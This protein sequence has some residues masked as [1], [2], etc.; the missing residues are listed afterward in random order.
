MTSFS[1]VTWLPLSRQCPRAS[2]CFPHGP[3]VSLPCRVAMDE[4]PGTKLAAKWQRRRHIRA[5]A[6]MGLVLVFCFKK[7]ECVVL[8]GGLC[9]WMPLAWLVPSLLVSL[10]RLVPSCPRGIRPADRPTEPACVQASKQAKWEPPQP[11]NQCNTT[12]RLDKVCSRIDR[13]LLVANRGM[14]GRVWVLDDFP[15]PSFPRPLQWLLGTETSRSFY[16]GRKAQRYI[17]IRSR[18]VQLDWLVWII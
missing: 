11:T 6:A 16:Y 1:P 3:A 4:T 2:Y 5:M 12:T 10:S 7:C 9:V 8:G 17:L 15:L 14:A 13:S 18:N